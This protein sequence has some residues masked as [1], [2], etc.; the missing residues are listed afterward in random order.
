MATKCPRC[1]SY[2]TECINRIKQVG[3]CVRKYGSMVAGYTLA[4]FGHH[5]LGKFIFSPPEGNIRR[6]I[7]KCNS[8]GKT[9]KI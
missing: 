5:N 4:A 9:F 7:Y 8:C 1:G 6:S 2:N 3:D